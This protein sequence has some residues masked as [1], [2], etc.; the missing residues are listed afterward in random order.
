MAIKLVTAAEMREI[1]R[2]TI[3]ERGVPG[4]ELMERAGRSVADEIVERYAPSAVGIVTGKGNNA[5]DGLVVARMLARRGIAATVLML[6]PGDNLSE[7][8]R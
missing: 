3:H 7:A 5:G 8:G 1:D 4:L 6:T 2:V